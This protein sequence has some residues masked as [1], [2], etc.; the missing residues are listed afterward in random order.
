MDFSFDSIA[1][2]PELQARAIFHSDSTKVFR[3]D[4]NLNPI[5]VDDHT[6]YIPWGADNLMPFEVLQKIEADETL[7]TCQLFNAEVCYGAGLMYQTSACTAQVKDG[8]L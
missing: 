3:E 1:I 2:V 6:S 7:S 8:L 5:I 4:E